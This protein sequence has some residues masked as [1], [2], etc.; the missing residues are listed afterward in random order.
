MSIPEFAVKRPITMLMIIVSVLVIGL[1]SLNRLPLTFFPEFSS[2]HLRIDVPYPSSS[3]QEVERLITKP[4][5]D[6]MGT[7]TNLESM[8]SSS[9]GSGSNVNLEFVAGTDMDLASVEVRDRIDR[10]R[11]LLPDDVERVNIRRWQTTDMPVFQFSVAWNKGSDALYDLVNKILI[12]QLQRI[13]GVANVDIRGMD[14]RKVL[15]ELDLERM[16]AHQL[17]FFQ[18]A[19]SLRQNNINVAGGTVMQGGREFSV[20]TIGEYRTVEEIAETPI[21]GSSLVLRDVAS[22]KFAFPEKT[23]FGRLNKS[24]AVDLQVYKAST[25]NVIDVAEKSLQFLNELKQESKYK[26]V[27]IQVYRDQSDEIKTSLLNLTISGLL[28]AVLAVLILYFFLRKV[29][30]TIIIA[31]AIPISII[32]TFLLI[33]LLRMAPFNS[34]ITINIVSLSGLM[35]AVGMLVDPAV[36]VLENIF[37]HKQEEKLNA[38]DAAIVGAKEVAVAVTAAVLTTVIVFVPMLFMEGGGF[39]RWM[40]DFGVAICVASIASLLMSLTLIPLASSFLFTGEEKQKN[41]LIAGLSDGY[42][43]IIGRLV[44]FPVSLV[45]LLFGIGLLWGTWYLKDLIDRDWMPRTPSR[46]MDLGMEIDRNFSIDE[47]HVMFDSLENILLKNKQKFEID[48]VAT[49]YRK[50]GGRLTIYFIPEEDGQK[51]TTELYDE[52]RASLPEFAGVEFQVGRRH[53]RG[54]NE[55]G[56][57][58]ELKG[59]SLS[60]LRTFAE[61]IRHRLQGIDGIKD[62]DTSLE[63][64]DEELQVT[65]DRVRSQ[66]IGLSAQDVARSISSALGGRSTSRFKAQDR[67]VD[68]L[69]QLAEEDRTN[70]QQLENMALQNSEQNMV[71]VSSVADMQLRKGPQTIEREDR[72][73]TVTV[74]ANTDSRGMFSVSREINKRLA[75]L[76]LP[77]GYSWSLG[78]NFQEMQQGEQDSMFAIWLAVIL[79][80]IV[81]ASLFE[82]FIHPFTIMFSVPFALSGVFLMFWLTDTNLTTMGWLGILVVCGLVVNNGI[83]LIDAIN[84]RR[85]SGFSR[86]EAII[87]GGKNRVRPIL[88]TTLTTIL[89]LAPLV[90]PAMFPQFFGP[91]EGRSGMYSPVGIAI[92]GGLVTSTPLTLFIIPVVY[93]FLDDLTRWAKNVLD[94]TLKRSRLTTATQES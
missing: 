27:E 34:T 66:N 26:G 92:V 8:S 12:P 40:G 51:N 70:R 65:V 87:I 29:R 13:E 82:S 49:D 2:S 32:T 21:R 14:E 15:V 78:R 10:V 43:K 81:M 37:R 17:D 89:G 79:I 86:T 35:F 64:G 46:R 45:V 69:M 50:R 23:R 19:S 25:A 84:K 73:S 91:Q 71:Q 93:V 77:P 60:V 31:M 39:G 3:P 85:R 42:A 33:Y 9:S 16:R 53:G 55:E 22:V 54:G 18:L 52:I 94:N 67:E 6:M 5:E 30:S 74:F 90:I 83:I 41:K 4:I 76:N 80:Y 63:R 28:G 1:L 38:I 47:V 56:V 44:R 58:I 62:I 36:V 57:S 61:E 59:E 75:D 7:V 20:R 88:M 68:I 11:S 72:R 24:N 48:N